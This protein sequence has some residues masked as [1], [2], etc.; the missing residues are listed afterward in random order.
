[1]T[2]SI[3]PCVW[4]IKLIWRTCYSAKRP[5]RQWGFNWQL[6]TNRK[7]PIFDHVWWINL[8]NVN[9]TRICLHLGLIPYAVVTAN[10]LVLITEKY[11]TRPIQWVEPS[12]LPGI[13]RIMDRQ[14]KC[15]LTQFDFVGQVHGSSLALHLSSK[16]Q[17]DGW[18]PFCSM[19]FLMH[20]TFVNFPFWKQLIVWVP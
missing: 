14:N 18:V 9:Y 5:C 19:D 15:S 7:E 4:N 20:K 3:H 1:M 10:E 16:L 2:S 17:V 6:F 11:S 12:Y 13:I 8:S